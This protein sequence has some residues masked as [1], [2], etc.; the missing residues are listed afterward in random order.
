MKKI[1]VVLAILG[2]SGCSRTAQLVPLNDEASAVGNPTI[3][4]TLY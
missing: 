4:L 3:D 1:V 2:L